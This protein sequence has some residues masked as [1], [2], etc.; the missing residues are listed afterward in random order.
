MKFF[1]LRGDFGESRLVSDVRILKRRF[2]PLWHKTSKDPTSS[3]ALKFCFLAIRI[4]QHSF[5]DIPVAFY[6]LPCTV[7][8][9]LFGHRFHGGGRPGL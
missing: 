6:S 5:L 8:F 7:N 9:F 2:L 4:Q 1:G 3:F